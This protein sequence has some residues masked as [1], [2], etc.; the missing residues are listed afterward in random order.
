MPPPTVSLALAGD[1]MT[2]R[3]VDQIL[4]HPSDPE[5]R[6]SYIRDARGY[7]R[8]AESA[9]GPIPQPVGFDWPW[10]D[11]L[12]VMD[13]L[14]PDVRL[15]NLETSITTSRA[16]QPGKGIHYRMHPANTA[17]L[18]TADIQVCT[19]ANNH[20][21]DFGE[22]G[23]LETLRTL[24]E[25]GI[26]TAGAG[27]D[28]VDAVRPAVLPIG[29]V[30]RLVVFSLGHGSSG[31]PARWAAAPDRPGV[32]YLADLSP[33]SVARVVER[34]AAIRQ[35]ND[36]V[37]VSIHWGSNWGY[38]TSRE[39][40]RFAHGLIDGGADIIHGHSSHHP[41]QVQIYRGRPVLYGCGDLIN[42]YEGIGGY[43]EFR[44]DLRLLYF[45]A[46]DASTRELVSLRAAA[47][48][49]RRMRLERASKEAVRWL[50]SRLDEVSHGRG[51]QVRLA[52]D[53]LLSIDP[54]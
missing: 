51:V 5:L 54:R 25:A 31:V 15:I 3:G 47:F 7:V 24:G 37:V 2:G 4:P 53:G 52:A 49:V 32:D 13:G 44:D 48:Q 43:E 38:E 40:T 39:Q 20:V 21:L 26:I 29:D 27:R 17:C 14:A 46:L 28:L 33:H 34:I 6:E 16:Y 35:P 18:T 19:L 36:V 1:V 42:D 30:G 11:A 22:A 41:R 8:L 9:N 23:L 45:A 10:G 50:A 12:E